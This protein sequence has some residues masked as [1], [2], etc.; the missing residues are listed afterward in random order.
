MSLRI[1]DDKLLD[2]HKTMWTKIE[3][4]Q[5]IELNALPLTINQTYSKDK[6]LVAT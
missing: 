6:S 3:D 5:N 1:D 4:L 2:E